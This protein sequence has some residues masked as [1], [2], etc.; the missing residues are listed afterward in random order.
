MTTGEARPKD[1]SLVPLRK[2]RDFQI[3]WSAQAVSSLGTTVSQV[4][5]P[6]LILALTGSATYAGLMGTVE[7]VFLL[8]ATLPAGVI[9]DR[10]DRRK[11]M[12][13]CDIARALV[14]GAMV[15]LVMTGR[16]TVWMILVAGAL[17][18]IGDGMFGPAARGALKQIV[19][20]AQLASATAAREGRSAVATMVGPPLA[21][22]LFTV[23]RAI[24]FVFDAVSYVL[25]AIAL[26]FI[27]RPFQ[28]ERG[29]EHA[30]PMWKGATAGFVFVFGNASLR[31]LMSWAVLVN[32]AFAGVPVVLIAHATKTGAGSTLTGLMLTILGVGVL[33]GSLASPWLVKVLRPSQVIHLSAFALPLGLGVMVFTPSPIALGA[34]I[35]AAAFMVPVGNSMLG[36]YM[37]AI[38]PDRLQG[39]VGAAM[40]LSAMG[41]KPL[42]PLA[43]GLVFDHFGVGWAFASAGALALLAALLTLDRDVRH[44]RRPE[45]LAV[46]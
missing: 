6:L 1:D 39:R 19:P 36:G 2:N 35:G 3:L 34:L 33:A 11:I 25:G 27:R 20:A 14:L 45:E 44:M 26:L 28:R 13:G 7:M 21:G 42:G 15:V 46:E 18:S 12:I 9:A 22:L 32:L 29:A 38:V 31:A 8:V 16:A 5:Y 10:F 37:G 40:S 41:L 23:G 43:L 4:A 30:E 24:P 17:T